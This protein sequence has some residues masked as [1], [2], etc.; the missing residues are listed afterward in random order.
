MDAADPVF[1]AC[2]S[3]GADPERDGVLF[4]E[5]AAWMLSYEGA[6]AAA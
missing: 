2:R 6:G 5:A 1:V 3:T 4:L